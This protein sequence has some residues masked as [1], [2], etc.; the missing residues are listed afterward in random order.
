MLACKRG[1]VEMLKLLTKNRKKPAKVNMTDSDGSR[2]ISVAVKNQHMKL[3]RFLLL[4]AKAK[5]N[6]RCGRHFYTTPLTMACDLEDM[7][8]VKLLIEN[9]TDMNITDFQGV[10]P[11]WAAVVS[12]NLELASFLLHDNAANPNVNVNRIHRYH[13][14]NTHS[15][16]PLIEACKMEDMNMVRMLLEN[17]SHPA[18]INMADGNGVRPL[19]V[20]LQTQNLDLVYMLLHLRNSKLDLNYACVINLQSQYIT[21]SSCQL[22]LFFIYIQDTS[23]H[24]LLTHTKYTKHIIH[25]G[26]AHETHKTNKRF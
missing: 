3:L 5:P 8:I 1:C 6:V 4:E 15:S 16:T 2:P 21:T 25:T 12:Q 17:K 18:D 22:V 19:S 9:K 23:H 13:I 20:A 24:S 11:I 7:D 26:P 14:K 10:C